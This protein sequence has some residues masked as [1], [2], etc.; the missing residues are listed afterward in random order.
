MPG[1][2]PT[3]MQQTSTSAQ[4]VSDP[5]PSLPNPRHWYG[6]RDETEAAILRARYQRLEAELRRAVERIQ[7][8]GQDGYDRDEDEE[9]ALQ[10]WIAREPEI[11]EEKNEISKRLEEL[12]EETDSEEDESEEDESESSA[13]PHAPAAA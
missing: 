11:N 1:P 8:L 4:Q 5:I 3:S 6:K 12:D 9:E 13:P 7:F 10:Y 2:T